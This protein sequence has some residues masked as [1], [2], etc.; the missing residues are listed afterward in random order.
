MVIFAGAI[1]ILASACTDLAQLDFA[2]LTKGLIGVGALLA[3]V[4]LFMNTAK[5]SGRSISTATGILVLAGAMKVF[6]SACKDFGQMN[7]GELV[8]GLGS[9]GVLLLE[10]TAFAKLAGNVKGLTATGFA[11]IEIGTAM[12][13]FASAMAD[14]GSMSLVGIGKGLL[15]M[16]GALAE[17]AIAMKVMPKNR[18]ATGTGLITVGAALNVLANALSKMGGMSWESVAK[19]LVAMGGALAELAIGLNFMNGTLSGSAAM[20]VAAGALTVL[21][22]VLFTLG[23]M[24]WAAIA[25]GLITVAGAFAIIGTAGVLLT[26]LLPTILGLGGVFALI[27]RGVTGVGA[28]LL[29]VGTGLSAIAVGVTALATSLGAGV[30][31]IVAGLTSIITGIAALISCYCSKIGRG[32]SVRLHRSSPME[33]LLSVRLSRHLCSRWWMFSL[34]ASLRSQMA[35]WN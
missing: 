17:I 32:G 2:G 23:S 25:K 9:I 11:L 15:A 33:L 6:A 4:S 18:I 26:P 24:S 34:S 14:F 10:I 31:V 20:L 22:P 13:I 21:T 30:A 35:Q 27:W 12:K 8:K 16:G 5:F 19:S 7:V 29:L 3:E 28:G 1:K